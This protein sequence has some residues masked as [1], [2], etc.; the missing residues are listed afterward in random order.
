MLKYEDVLPSN[1][2]IQPRAKLKL[3]AS[4]N[5]SSQIPQIKVLDTLKVETQVILFTPPNPHEM[6]FFSLT[7]I[8]L[9]LSASDVRIGRRRADSMIIDERDENETHR[10][11]I[12]VQ[13]MTQH[14]PRREG[15]PTQG[16]ETL[17]ASISQ[18]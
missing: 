14:F 9:D 10:M 12:L 11:D 16:A 15:Q 3:Q 13:K 1:S 17:Q 5:S 4:I 18:V 7:P 6:Q 2:N 8:T